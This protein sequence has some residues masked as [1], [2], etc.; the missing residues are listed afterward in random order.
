MKGAEKAETRSKAETLPSD[1]GGCSEGAERQ[2][3]S[4]QRYDYKRQLFFHSQ[5]RDSPM[6][7]W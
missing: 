2:K 5:K 4:V 3:S 6:E 7:V 1:K